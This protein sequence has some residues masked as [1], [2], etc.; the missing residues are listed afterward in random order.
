MTGCALR[1]GRRRVAL[2][3]I[4]LLGHRLCSS[5]ASSSGRP[6]RIAVVG[7]G[8]AGFYFAG[9]VK[10]LLSARCHLD[11]FD[12]S[13]LPFGLVRF[14]VAPDHPEVKNCTHQFEKLFAE[15]S[16]A[17]PRFFGNVAIGSDVSIAQLSARYDAV[18]LACGAESERKL[19]VP[20]EW[21]PNCLSARAFV[22]WYNGQPEHAHLEFS[23][24]TD[25]AVVLGVGNVALDVARV[26]LSPLER[27]RATDVSQHA[28]DQLTNSRLR[29][30]IL[31]ARRGP[32]Q[33]AFTI[34]ELR[35]LIHLPGSIPKLNLADFEDVRAS[36]EGIPRPRKRLT[37]L[38]LNTAE[39]AIKKSEKDMGKEWSIL[40]RRS[41]KQIL[42]DNNG[43][44]SGVELTLNKLVKKNGDWR[45]E[46]TDSIET[47]DCGLVVKSVG[48]QT[49]VIPGVPFDDRRQV[50]ETDDGVRVSGMDNVYACGWCARGPQ[51]V[52]AA[53]Q[54][55][56]KRC[57]LVVQ[58][59]IE[60]GKLDDV[61]DDKLDDVEE[62]LQS[63]DIQ[64][65]SWE[66]W[67]RIDALEKDQGGAR[68]KPREKLTSHQDILK[69]I[70]RRS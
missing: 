40:F 56:A 9:A 3:S 63:R 37:E 6:V 54:L 57:A 29:R 41:P 66:D 50:V 65:V 34:K 30:V 44:V 13:P 17:K 27:L 31:V 16:P 52:I 38:L 55:E 61:R 33:V 28:L 39:G 4:F 58:E 26:L 24:D 15:D 10:R 64:W 1:A 2:A 22:G 18:V 70:Q 46:A 67:L 25:T 20:N 42:V 59:D 14:G 45:A 19:N 60:S 36:I 35:E 53:T 51:G 69:L 68:G 21:A 62:V 43:K 12:K 49:V 5:R 11:L 23:L 8:P 47:I 7:T 32:L 48:Y